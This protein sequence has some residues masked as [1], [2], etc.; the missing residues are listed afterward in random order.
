MV[1]GSTNMFGNVGGFSAQVAKSILPVGRDA[2]RG[3]GKVAKR[4]SQKIAQ[5]VSTAVLPKNTVVGGV[6]AVG[7]WQARQVSLVY[8]PRLLDRAIT[9]HCQRQLGVH[10]GRVVALGVSPTL[11]AQLTPW[12][13]GL[14]GFVVS[15]ALLIGGNVVVTYVRSK[16]ADAER[17][18]Q[19]GALD[20]NWIDLS[21]EGS[22]NVHIEEIGD[23]WVVLSTPVE[24]VEDILGTS[25]DLFSECA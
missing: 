13:G 3:V 9:A 18:A 10:L 19:E 6:T 2:L 5:I 25:I 20:E 21:E 23:D 4:T 14:A 22:R 15:E 8:A 1:R 7:G 11:A 16:R 12:C 24:E 17:R